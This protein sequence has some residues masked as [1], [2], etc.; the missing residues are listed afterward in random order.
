MERRNRFVV[1][2]RLDDGTAVDAYL[3]N[4]SRMAGLLE[5]GRRILL[6]PT[7]DPARRTRFSVTRWWDDCWIGIHATEAERLFADH[8]TPEGT[9]PGLGRIVGLRP[10]VRLGSSVVDFSADLSDGTTAWVEVKSGSR[11]IGSDAPL[12]K[13]PSVRAVRHLDELGAAVVN[14]DRAAVVFVIQRPDVDRLV[15]GGDADAGWVDAVR[16]AQHTGVVV[17]AFGCAVD[18][19]SIRIDRSL[20][21]EFLEDAAHG[22]GE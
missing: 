14:G 20:E 19:D 5:P 18:E 3:P 13:T 12:S 4:T 7:D 2:A 17:A 16:R 22:S 6:D 9:V 1:R 21:V 8:V 11:A 10:Q 15:V